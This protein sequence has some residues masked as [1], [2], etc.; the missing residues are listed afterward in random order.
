VE[1]EPQSGEDARRERRRR[2]LIEAALEGIAAQGL[3]ETTVQD[4]AKR[5]GMAVGSISQYF[6]SKEQ[7]FT[8]LLVTL[9]D[10]FEACWRG[11]LDRAGTDPAARLRQFVLTYFDPLVFTP[12]KVA[13]WF[14]FWGEVTA[15]PQYRAVCATHDRVHDEVLQ[16]L[17]AALLETGGRPGLDAG[18]AAKTLTALCQGLWLET[19]TEDTKQKR[20]DYAALALLGLE[21]L[22]PRAYQAD[23]GA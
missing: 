17:C 11:G 5:A 7:L 3:R 10:E 16:A 13:V 19:L 1:P 9:S 23:F 20:Q 2:Q 15:R 12:R 8:A 6:A 4:V 14:A 21:A 22:F 18:Q